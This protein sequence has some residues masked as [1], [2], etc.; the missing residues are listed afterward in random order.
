MEEMLEFVDIPVL[1][2]IKAIAYIVKIPKLNPTFYQNLFIKPVV[3]NNSIVFLE[4]T[5][6]IL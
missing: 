2:S 1:N 6:C 3:K 4:L 5:K